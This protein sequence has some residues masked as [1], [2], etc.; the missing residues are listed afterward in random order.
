M[1]LAAAPPVIC[2]AV[3]GRLLLDSD[4]GAALGTPQ[5]SAPSSRV[6]PTQEAIRL[7]TL[8]GRRSVLA[9]SQLRAPGLPGNSGSLGN[10]RARGP[11][12]A[13][14]QQVSRGKLQPGLRWGDRQTSSPT[15]AIS[16]CSPLPEALETSIWL[17][18]PSSPGSSPLSSAAL[19]TSKWGL[20]PHWVTG[21][22]VS[23]SYD[24]QLCSVALA[25]GRCQTLRC[26]LHFNKE[27][28]ISVICI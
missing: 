11:G 5:C 28:C 19:Y 3:P 12:Q 8:A 13:E 25:L 26:N 10:H 17:S 23:C 27:S 2:T 14:S 22:G 9:I 1:G 20:S 16:G 7:T 4:L 24:P 6:L 21:W 15:S 18:I